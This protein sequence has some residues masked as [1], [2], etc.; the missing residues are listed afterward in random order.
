MATRI[1][2]LR[3]LISPQNRYSVIRRYNK[4]HPIREIIKHEEFP[5]WVEDVNDKNGIVFLI[6][7]DNKLYEMD[8]DVFLEVKEKMRRMIIR[9]LCVN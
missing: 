3:S 7:P 8:I 9:E 1:A 2:V 5:D 4:D 6:S